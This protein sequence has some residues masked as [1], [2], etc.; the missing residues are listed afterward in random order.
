[1]EA[2]SKFSGMV[3]IKDFLYRKSRKITVE[4]SKYLKHKKSLSKQ[5]MDQRKYN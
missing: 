5:S 1:V 2:I 4:K 3:K